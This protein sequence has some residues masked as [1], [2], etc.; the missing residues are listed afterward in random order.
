[1]LERELIEK[2]KAKEESAFKHAFGLFSSMI[3][4]TSLGLL[5]NHEEAED[6]VQ[7]V[8]IEL[9]N[10][11]HKF[12]GDSTLKTWIYKLTLSK[13][14]DLIRSKK[15]QKRGGLFSFL[16]FKNEESWMHQPDFNH[17][18]ILL[19]NKERGKILFKAI[20]QLAEKQKMAFTL[21]KLEG[22]SYK[23][24]SDIMDTSVPSVESLI[25]RAKKRLQILL[26]EFYEEDRK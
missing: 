22:C 1:M 7:E 21:N 10:S 6:M 26:K 11:I 3:L 9:L 15:R 18:G 19:E 25:H 2:L 12:K 13:S 14:L 23:E 20:D 17:P 8:M 16:S 5:Q 24:I 4:N